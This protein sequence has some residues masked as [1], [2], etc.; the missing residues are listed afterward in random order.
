[1]T[2]IAHGFTVGSWLG[3]VSFG[4][5]YEGKDSLIHNRVTISFAVSGLGSS[6]LERESRLYQ[7]LSG[8][9]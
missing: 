8:G 7:I 1:M 9:V 5:V 3:S 4:E 2:A 6:L